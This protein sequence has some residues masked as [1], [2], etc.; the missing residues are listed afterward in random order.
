M[1][2]QDIPIY[3]AAQDLFKQILASSGQAPR[4]VRGDIVPILRASARDLVVAVA[5]AKFF[6]EYRKALLAD[7][8]MGVTA[9]HE[10]AK[11]AYD[12]RCLTKNGFELILEHCESVSRQANGWANKVL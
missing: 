9:V 2:K 6:P 5:Q 7:V 10:Y 3:K 4:E 8:R 11:M 1:N 12:M